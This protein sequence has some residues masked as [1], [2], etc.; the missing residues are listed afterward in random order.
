M[1]E[2]LTHV[3]DALDIETFLI[4]ADEEQAKKMAL[5]MVADLGLPNGDV[6]FAQHLGSGARVRVRSYIHKP[7][8]KYYFLPRAR[9]KEAVT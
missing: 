1:T 9:E 2:V 5:Q 8:D 4:C 6:V 7:G 3:V